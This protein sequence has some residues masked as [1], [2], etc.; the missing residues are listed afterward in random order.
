MPFNFIQISPFEFHHAD[1][2]SFEFHHTNQISQ[3]SNKDQITLPMVWGMILLDFWVPHE[4]NCWDFQYLFDLGNLAKFELIQTTSIFIFSKN[5]KLPRFLG[6]FHRVFMRSNFV[7]FRKILN[8]ADPEDFIC[9][10]H[11]E[12]RNLPRSPKLWARSKI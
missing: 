10:S 5:P 3:W 12:P 2:I 1:Q 6:G 9:L 4:I 11:D 8:Q 7:R